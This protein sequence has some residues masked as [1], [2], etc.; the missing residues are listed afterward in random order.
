MSQQL[1][2]AMGILVRQHLNECE[3]HEDVSAFHAPGECHALGSRGEEQ[4]N[5]AA[6]RHACAVARVKSMR[7]LRR[8][9]LRVM[10]GAD[11]YFYR[12]YGMVPY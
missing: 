5:R 3:M 2:K 11:R 6:R 9:V 12:R 1:G 8:K 10:P 7:G 4:R